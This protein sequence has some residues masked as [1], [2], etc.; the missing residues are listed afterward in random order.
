VFEPRSPQKKFILLHV[1][2]HLPRGPPFLLHDGCRSSFTEVKSTERGV[3]HPPILK[4]NGVIPLLPP[5]R[6]TGKFLPFNLSLCV[7]DKHY[8]L[9]VHVVSL[10][11]AVLLPLITEIKDRD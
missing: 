7:T 3:D 11:T 8:N 4:M 6:V 1:H 9:C 10:S 2:P 5:W